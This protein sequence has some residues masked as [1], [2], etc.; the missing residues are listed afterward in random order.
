VHEEGRSE[1][2]LDSAQEEEAH[3]NVEGVDGV[4]L[5]IFVLRGIGLSILRVTVEVPR[6]RAIAAEQICAK[7][8]VQQALG[9]AQRCRSSPERKSRSLSPE[10]NSPPSSAHSSSCERERTVS[11]EFILSLSCVIKL[12]PSSDSASSSS[13]LLPTPST[14]AF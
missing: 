10:A 9:R 7:T 11:T 4:V 1:S 13:S 12:T 6:E 5:E 3:L 8:V 14:A 2:V